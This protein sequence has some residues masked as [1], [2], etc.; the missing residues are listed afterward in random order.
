MSFEAQHIT[1]DNSLV[2]FTLKSNINIKRDSRR[3]YLLKNPYSQNAKQIF[4]FT[5]RP[6]IIFKI[7]TE[8]LKHPVYTP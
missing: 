6:K 8:N 5:H 4:E 2:S 7:C 3:K 1:W